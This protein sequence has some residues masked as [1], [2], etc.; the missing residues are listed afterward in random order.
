MTS[1]DGK[2]PTLAELRRLVKKPPQPTGRFGLTPSVIAAIPTPSTIEEARAT[3]G[4]H[5]AIIFPDGIKEVSEVTPEVM[6]FALIDEASEGYDEELSIQVDK[7]GHTE[8]L[9]KRGRLRFIRTTLGY[10]AH[11]VTQ[12]L[13]IR[14]KFYEDAERKLAKYLGITPNQVKT[15]DVRNR[16]KNE[17]EKFEQRF[18][19]LFTVVSAVERFTINDDVIERRVTLERP[20][21]KISNISIGSALR[22][23]FPNIAVTIALDTVKDNE[24]TSSDH[25]VV[26]LSSI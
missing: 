3:L 16:R 17:A 19:G 2:R 22:G 24:G 20:S 1:E 12:S 6:E 15:E 23:G 4:E 5:A 10:R 18:K 25:Q 7:N 11:P 26:G 13:G 21:G 8:L 9:G 14:S